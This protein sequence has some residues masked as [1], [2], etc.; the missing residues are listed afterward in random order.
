MEN[1]EANGV[2]FVASGFVYVFKGGAGGNGG[3]V[4]I[5]PPMRV[6]TANMGGPKGRGAQY[7]Y[8]SGHAKDWTSFLPETVHIARRAMRRSPSLGEDACAKKVPETYIVHVARGNETNEELLD[9]V[10]SL[11]LVEFE[12]NVRGEKT[13]IQ[14]AVEQ[15]WTK[16]AWKE[17]AKKDKK[18][19]KKQ[20]KLIAK[21]AY[22]PLPLHKDESVEAEVGLDLE[23]SEDFSN[24]EEGATII[25]S[26][27]EEVVEEEE[28][29]V[30]V[31]SLKNSD[32]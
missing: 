8:A 5:K 32:L 31:A 7:P 21:Y 27:E 9:V 19:R 25:L 10:E 26:E 15:W 22:T 18:W 24:L 14:R 30:V 3:A 13:G 12:R 2:S 20:R 11:P 4:D 6:A 23:D 16:K 29:E 17:G 1:V 28:E